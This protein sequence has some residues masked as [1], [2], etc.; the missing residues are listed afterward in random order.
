M[1]TA[2]VFKG[3]AGTRTN[4]TMRVFDE[5]GKDVTHT[6]CFYLGADG[7]LYKETNDID[8]PLVEDTEHTYEMT[9]E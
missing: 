4:V 2:M 9:V 3:G 8:M 7:L 1:K 5:N 6:G